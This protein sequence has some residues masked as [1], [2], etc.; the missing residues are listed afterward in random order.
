MT[1]TVD[2]AIF[3]TIIG[4]VIGV[5]TI[6]KFMN[7]SLTK[8]IEEHPKVITLSKCVQDLGTDIG[9]IKQ[10]LGKVEEKMDKGL[11]KITDKVDR[12]VDKLL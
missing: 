12:L 7:G 6:W 1:F 8:R 3:G 5:I 9:E 10:S 2:L 4:L 11:E